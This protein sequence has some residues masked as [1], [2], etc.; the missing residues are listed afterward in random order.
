MED[1]TFIDPEK[2]ALEFASSNTERVDFDDGQLVHNSKNF[3]MSYLTAYYL[4]ENFNKIESE[5][6]NST[7]KT[8]F[9]DLTFEQL[10]NKVRNLNKY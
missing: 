7:E 4:V 5:L 10:K 6:F 3:L 8:N 2:F 1:R 9:A